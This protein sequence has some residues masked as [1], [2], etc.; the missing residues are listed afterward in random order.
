RAAAGLGAAQLPHP[1]PGHA[2]GGPER[3]DA[4]ALPSHPGAVP[5]AV[6]G[7]RG[8]DRRRPGGA[9]P[10]PAAARPAAGQLHLRRRLPDDQGAGRPRRPGHDRR[11]RDA[12]GGR[13]RGHNAAPLPAPRGTLHQLPAAE[14]SA[15][16]SLMG[17]LRSW[18]RPAWQ[19]TFGATPADLEAIAAAA[20]E[21]LAGD[22]ELTRDELVAAIVDRARSAHLAEV[23][24]SGWGT[25]LKPLAWWGVLCN[26]M[27]RGGRVT[28]R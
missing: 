6:P 19:R 27:P 10:V 2:D 3:A 23:L 8:A 26:G 1:D 18:E 16:L 22:R 7:R 13:R 11:P 21:A 25:L 20:T 9:P 4:L 17:A 14:G 28:F 12:G 5:A 15:Y 24:G